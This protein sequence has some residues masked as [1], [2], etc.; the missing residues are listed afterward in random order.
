MLDYYQILGLE[1][2]ASKDEIKKA[3]RL[4]A[5]KY[6][7]DK[8]NGDKFFEERFKEINEAH[9]ILID[10]EKRAIYDS[11]LQSNKI[12]S[13][14]YKRERDYNKKSNDYYKREEFFKREEENLKKDEAKKK[15]EQELINTIYFKN[16]KIEINGISVLVG[17]LK[18]PFSDF[19][20]V[21]LNNVDFVWDTNRKHSILYIIAVILIW[22]SIF[23]MGI[24]I[25]FLL[26]FLAILFLVLALFNKVFKFL[27]KKIIDKYFPIFVLILDG[28]SGEKEIMTG[29]KSKINELEKILDTALKNYHNN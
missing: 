28:K 8:Q 6:H 19:Q 5:T 17:P 20:N 27:I 10:E 4:Y 1:K 26:F 22:I 24:G 13:D 15:R 11:K 7:P 25:G 29:K 9:E 21:R 23:T 12:N 2:N 14:S 3:Y 18:F 16:K